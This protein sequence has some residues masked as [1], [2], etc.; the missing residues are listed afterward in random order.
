MN[1]K[2]DKS[3]NSGNILAILS[4][5]KAI[6]EEN[7]FY[8]SVCAQLV[9]KTN[10][11]EKEVNSLKGELN[12]LRQDQ[13]RNNMI[14]HGLPKLSS[15]NIAKVIPAI[16]KKLNIKSDTTEF[17]VNQIITKAKTQLLLVKFNYIESKFKFIKAIKEQGLT[18]D[19]IGIVGK[20]KKIVFTNHLTFYNLDLLQQSQILKK[21]HQF[22]FIWFQSGVILARLHKDSKIYRIK[23]SED[24]TALK[25]LSDSDSK[26]QSSI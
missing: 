12:F 1:K 22:E 7:N 16:T 17:T 24:I 21:D 4:E 25:K 10:S 26:H 19:Q 8:K 6:R 18:T 23:T 15:E 5:I 20:S 14:I 3:D 9:E 13:L 11:L 2:S